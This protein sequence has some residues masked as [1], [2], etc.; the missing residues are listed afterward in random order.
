MKKDDIRTFVVVI[1][2]CLVF[3]IL[4][5]VLNHKNNYEKL[6]VVNNYEEFF[7]VVDDVN[8]YIGY[9]SNGDKDGIFNVLDNKYISNNF[10]TLD[11]VLEYID[12]LSELDS[13]KAKE[14][15][16]VKIRK[17]YLYYV[18]GS[19]IKNDL[20]SSTVIDDN[21]RVLVSVDSS[22]N[23]YS[24][25]PISGNDEEVINDIKK[26][27]IMNNNYNDAKKISEF[28]D[29]DICKLY[30]FDYINYIY[31]NKKE[32]YNF[33][34]DSMLKIYSNYDDFSKYI[35]DNYDKFTSS[36]KLCN[37]SNF[38]DGSIISVVDSRENVYTFN[39]EGVMN[40]KVKFKLK[41]TENDE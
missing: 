33:L 37:V 16:Y 11:N 19:I 10:I 38:D 35:S 22:N 32:A 23:C 1:V 6:S 18:R 15:S 5:F 14:I 2:V 27:A 13:F 8:E 39:V 20:D 4:F 30:Y 25:Y 34:D 12:D 40:Y 28:K 41:E 31:D 3:S 24:I 29:I 17:N 26:I 21:Y 9:V 7:S 36:T